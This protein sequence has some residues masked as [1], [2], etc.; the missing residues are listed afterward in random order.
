[1]IQ[2]W[3]VTGDFQ[4]AF[5]N[6]DSCQRVRQ[7]IL[8]IVKEHAVGGVIFNGDLKAA[9][10]PV[11]LRVTEFFLSFFE[12]LGKHVVV[13]LGNHDRLGMYSDTSSWLPILARSGA[14]VVDQPSWL[15]NLPIAVL[16]FR[17][18]PKQLATDLDLLMSS[19]HP[20]DIA[21]SLIVFHN[22]VG[23]NQYIA[24]EEKI[25]TLPRLD[26][27]WLALG[28]HI[29]LPQKVTDHVAYAGSPFAMDW[30]E[31]NQRKRFALVDF[32][33]YSLKWIYSELPG[34]Y[35]MSL[36][37][38][39]EPADWQGARIRQRV[40]IPAGAD[41][42]VETA[43]VRK[44][45]EAKYP[46]AHLF[47]P[48]DYEA[49]EQ[50]AKPLAA[51]DDGELIDQYLLQLKV[52]NASDMA[53][54]LLNRLRKASWV[55]R[56]DA[57]TQFI[58]AWGKNVLGFE[59]V[60]VN[61]HEAGLVVV[62]G[63]NHDWEGRSNGSGKTGLLSLPAIA[64]FGKTTKEQEHD[65]W[66]TRGCE[67]TAV[68][69]NE[70]IDASGR[71]I[72]VERS[73]YPSKLRMWI[74]A[75][76]VSTGMGP[77]ETQKQIEETLGMDWDTFL[78][79]VY[80]DDEIVRT[81][82]AGKK[83]ERSKLLDRFQNLERFAKATEL[84]KKDRRRVEKWK[85][86]FEVTAAEVAGE[87]RVTV[88]AVKMAEEWEKHVKQKEK[89]LVKREAKLADQLET[90]LQAQ[91]EK[92][93]HL[94]GA[95]KELKRLRAINDTQA[96]VMTAALHELETIQSRVAYF[97][98]VGADCTLCLQP[99]K[100]KKAIVAKYVQLHEAA[101]KAYKQ[102]ELSWHEANKVFQD[103]N[104]GMDVL[105]G[106]VGDYTILVNQ[107]DQQI[108]GIE[109]QLQSARAE[110]K[111]HRERVGDIAQRQKDLWKEAA[112]MANALEMAADDL[113][114]SDE[115]IQ[116]FS[117][118]GLPHWLRWRICP[119]LNLA[120]T[121]YAD[122]FTDGSL[123]ARFVDSE[124]GVD[125]EIINSSGG[126][127]WESQSSGEKR[128][129]S[130]MIA[131]ALRQIT[132]QSS[133]LILDEPGDGLDAYNA[134]LFA[135]SVRK[136]QQ[137]YGSVFLITHNDTIVGELSGESALVVSKSYGVSTVV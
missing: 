56:K 133:L 26:E 44:E 1:M 15:S 117:N 47:L 51:G 35:D 85:Q 136:I 96:S 82:I 27:F 89:E 132:G 58:R 40:F 109:E 110:G 91:K 24:G 104:R 101:R 62:T 53:D 108:K 115:A 21:D 42:W 90:T 81:L 59:S 49:T 16:P 20:R 128:L 45:L 79:V 119:A 65:Q 116:H 126:A 111:Q 86:Q 63:V 3:L 102:A 30:S 10:N 39:K 78:C 137:D 76:E 100:N 105:G 9:Y 75:D 37:G 93:H 121:E 134:R 61:M 118:Q 32:S 60:S 31:I 54:Y 2:R 73:R 8:R 33:D 97:K 23:G 114:F 80:L 135:A 22:D 112:L 46:G 129:L 19:A 7:Q 57:Q 123:R 6:L 11:D 43:K 70:F 103:H 99:V 98:S 36:P 127:D 38:F 55:R 72:V 67:E 18:D 124:D 125:I 66:A 69:G 122:L 131:F 87:L 25:L 68:C 29:H 83:S 50:E 94:A 106:E 14:T 52:T 5:G 64:N 41:S 107:L 17:T 92:E 74:D 4:C 88:E 77:R 130:L 34:W 120:I 12:E 113:R 84:L 48:P 71:R 95:E 28:G 13:N